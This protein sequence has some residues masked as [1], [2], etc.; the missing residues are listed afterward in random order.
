MTFHSYG[1][2]PRHGKRFTQLLYH[3][4]GSRMTSDVEVQN[5]APAMLD[6]EEAIQELE[7]QR[8]HGKKSKATITSRWLARKASQCL[9]G[10]P[11]RRRRCR[12][13]ATVRSENVEAELQKFPADLQCSPVRILSR[14]TADQS[15]NLLAHFRSAAARQRSPAP[16]EAEACP[17]PS[18]HRLRCHNDQNIRPSRPYVPQSGPEEAGAAVQ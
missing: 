14:H 8:E 10:S 1:R 15:P 3:P 6:Y 9:A 7:G 5:P 16:V 18:D 17:M 13:L 12:Y 2:I 4:L 11:R